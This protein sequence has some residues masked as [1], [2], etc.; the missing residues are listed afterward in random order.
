MIDTLNIQQQELDKILEI[1]L[2]LLKDTASL[3][4]HGL[5]FV[6]T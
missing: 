4:D 1:A 5:R 2:N 6:T 3:A